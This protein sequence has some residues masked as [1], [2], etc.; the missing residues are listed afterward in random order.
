MTEPPMVGLK[1][2]EGARYDEDLLFA[3]EERHEEGRMAARDGGL[4]GSQSIGRA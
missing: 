4:R 3:G 2:M 1:C